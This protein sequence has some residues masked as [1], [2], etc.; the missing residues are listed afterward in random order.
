MLEVLKK[1]RNNLPTS[2]SGDGISA[3]VEFS[4]GFFEVDFLDVALVRPVVDL[5]VAVRLGLGSNVGEVGE[6]A[7]FPEDL[8]LCTMMLI[9]WWD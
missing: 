2:G 9:T 8:K 3:A 4:L 5:D 1:S 6:R 7:L